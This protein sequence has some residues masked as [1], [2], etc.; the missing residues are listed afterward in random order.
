MTM[1]GLVL[2]Y[3][4]YC[5]YC[6][7]ARQ[8]LDALR[9]EN[10]AFAALPLRMVEESQQAAL[11]N[12]YDYYYVPTFYWGQQKLAEG[13]MDEEDVRRVLEEALQLAGEGQ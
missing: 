3:L 13:S 9:A 6:R 8:Y 10:P 11:A 4:E 7:R 12:Q 2:F 1:D 5:P